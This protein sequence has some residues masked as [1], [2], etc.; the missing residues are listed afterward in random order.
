MDGTANTLLTLRIGHV[1]LTCLREGSAALVGKA[2]AKVRR[3]AMLDAVKSFLVLSKDST[4]EGLS[5]M[6][7]KLDSW[8]NGTPAEPETQPAEGASA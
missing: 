8:I 6:G 3:Q 4:I 7:Q 5:A 2:G 1:T